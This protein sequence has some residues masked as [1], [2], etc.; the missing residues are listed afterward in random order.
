MLFR[1]SEIENAVLSGVADAG[2]IIHENRFTYADKG[3]EKICDLGERWEQATGKP[4]PL[5]GIAVRNDLTEE[6]RQ[7][8]DRVLRRSVEFAFA[9]PDSSREFVKQHAREMDETVRQKH[10]ATYVNSY[11]TDLGETGRNAVLM[12][13]E[14]ARQAGLIK[15]IPESIFTG[16]EKPALKN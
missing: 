15:A 4:V 8:I 9:H 10:I 7:K 11:S 6:T 13:F 5:G 16:L 1:S 3:L 2:V 12:L 14:K